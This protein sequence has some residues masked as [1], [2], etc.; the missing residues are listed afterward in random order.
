MPTR[1]RR[2]IPTWTT[3]Q[4]SIG[5]RSD[6]F[7][8]IRERWP[9]ERALYPG[10]YLDLSP[11][12]AISSVTYLDTDRR[13][14]KFF[15]EPDLIR[16]DLNNKTTPAGIN[17]VA[18][19]SADYTSALPLEDDSFDLLISLYAGP[20]WDHCRK[21]LRPGGLLLANSSH[22][23]ASIAALDPDLT[24]IAAVHHRDSEY[25]IDEQDISEYLIPKSP[26]AADAQK[27]RDNGRGIVYT[28][29]AFAYIFQLR[30]SSAMSM[31]PL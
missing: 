23:D 10:S 29:T 28:R 15:A 8:T 14:A 26:A 4:Q 3:Y 16:R 6:L 5:D 12:T 18:F 13:A 27:I 1:S 25:R 21:Y 2:P 30:M 7:S 20:V 22:G 24:P 17:E 9:I 31:G 11:S 19:L